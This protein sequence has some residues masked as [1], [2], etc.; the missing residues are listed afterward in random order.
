[1]IKVLIVDDEPKLREGLKFFIDWESY[2]YHVVD[3]AANGYDALSKYEQHHPDVVIAD[4][5]MPGMDG[6]QLIKALRKQDNDLHILIL[7]GYADFDYAKKAITHRADGYLLKPVDEEELIS[8]LETIKQAIELKEMSAQ[9]NNTA[10]E[11]NR[12]ALI[13]ALI[14]QSTYTLSQNDDELA[15]DELVL[16][17]QAD[18]LG[19]LWPSYQILLIS[20]QY[21]DESDTTTAA[22]LKKKLAD[23]YEKSNR[24]YSFTIH[25]LVGVLLKQP[26]LEV[27]LQ[28]LYTYIAE[29]VTPEAAY[30]TAA[31]SSRGY[32][33]QQVKT[34]FE[35]A[36]ELLR[37]HFILDRGNILSNQLTNQCDDQCGDQLDEQETSE[38]FN[39]IDT[40][41]FIEKLYYAIDISNGS[42]ADKLIHRIGQYFVAEGF[43]EKII[44]QR[45]AEILNVV[46][47]KFVQKRSEQ[48]IKNVEFS[49][50]L[51]EIYEVRTLYELYE[52][53]NLIVK[54]MM[55]NT[56]PEG[57]HQE[58]KIMLDLIQRNYSDNLKLETLA[59]VFNYNSA[60]LGKLFKNETGEYFNTYVDK[61]RIEKAKDF[62]EQGYKVYQVAEKVGYTNVDY[63]HT[64]FRKYVGTSPSAYRKESESS[65]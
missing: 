62:L 61:V 35:E 13:S 5:R 47:T 48:D 34:C 40:L 19:L 20:V 3:T 16:Y 8:Y 27:E 31:I 65:S 10:K 15:Q 25:S 63:F 51:A 23:L 4:I 17:E 41:T 54:E 24:G 58:V 49:D 21:E 14:E 52:K 53:A 55:S 64:K 60:Y 6:I 2:G 50:A 45:F 42:L 28:E 38:G 46:F 22:L 12:E 44:K 43:N 36:K 39:K 29:I 33:L 37:Q 30:F 18:E 11:Y 9:W 26:L 57:K 56:G 1:M 59:G 7:S 32:E